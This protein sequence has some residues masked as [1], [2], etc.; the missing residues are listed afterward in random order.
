MSLRGVGLIAGYAIIAFAITLTL[1]R[2]AGTSFFNLA[3]YFCCGEL[4]GL[5]INDEVKA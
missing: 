3:V 4:A 5:A 1:E 2:F